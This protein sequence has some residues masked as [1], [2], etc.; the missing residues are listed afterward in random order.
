MHVAGPGARKIVLGLLV[1]GEKPRLSR[2]FRKRIDRNIYSIKHFDIESVANHDGFD[3]V[4]GFFN[5]ISGLMSYIHDVDLDLWCK[6][7]P[8]FLDIKN[9]LEFK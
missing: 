1:D 6:L 3:S 4:Y 2:K 9:S 8:R 7:Y 5:H